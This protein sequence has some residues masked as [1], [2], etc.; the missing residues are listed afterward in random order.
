MG[1][2]VRIDPNGKA[3]QVVGNISQTEVK[4]FPRLVHEVPRREGIARESSRGGRT[5][6]VQDDAQQRAVDL[7]RELTVVL[8]E[9][10]FLEF[11]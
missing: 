4:S 1:W 7:E 3:G 5:S 6:V 2:C 8:D 9:A 11:V 10:E